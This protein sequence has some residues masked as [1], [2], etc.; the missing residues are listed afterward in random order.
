MN[1]H[2]TVRILALA[3]YGFVLVLMST[4]KTLGMYE[5][6]LKG[7]AAYTGGDKWLHF[8]LALTLSLLTLSVVRALMYRVSLQSQVGATLLGLSLALTA[9]E[10]LQGLSA[11]RLVEVWDL[12]YGLS[13]VIVGL[14][15]YTIY[16]KGKSALSPE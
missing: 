15:L 1:F 10:L 9:E 11:T 12:F 3:G 14:A 5:Q 16:V 2:A 7:L 13:G 8:W 4:F 6:Q